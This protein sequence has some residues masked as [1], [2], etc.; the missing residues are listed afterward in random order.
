MG[1]DG[2]QQESWSQW[3]NWRVF[4]LLLFG[5]LMLIGAFTARGSGVTWW[6]RGALAAVGALVSVVLVRVVIAYRHLKVSARTAVSAPSDGDVAQPEAA[7]A[8]R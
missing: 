1:L 3:N 6:E 8:S 2:R 5:P 4:V 7:D